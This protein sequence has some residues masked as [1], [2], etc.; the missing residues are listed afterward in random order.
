MSLL[1]GTPEG[2]IAIAALS[3]GT[4]AIRYSFIGLL[5]SKQLGQ[6]TERALK[7]AIPAIFAALL[8]P[9][10]FVHDM[11]FDL[12]QR[13]PYA[14]AMVVTGWLAWQRGG[15]FLPVLAGMGT[16]HIGIRYLD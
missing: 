2:W 9:Y 7:M 11:A 6:R 5:A 8:V 4:F 14:L 1:W 15:M 10:A 3:V 12:A 16:L 13:W